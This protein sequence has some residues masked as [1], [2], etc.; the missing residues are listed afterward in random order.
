MTLIILIERKNW[1]MSINSI[2][3]NIK[4]SPKKLLQYACKWYYKSY[5]WLPFVVDN[6]FVPLSLRR[7]I[8]AG[9]QIYVCDHNTIENEIL[10]MF[11]ERRKKN[12]S[13]DYYIVVELS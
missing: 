13:N 12:S 5:C 2:F 6:A 10:N 4:I 1:P 3:V 8:E 9:T 11:G 7:S